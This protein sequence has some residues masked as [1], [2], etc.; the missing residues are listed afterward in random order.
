M[1]KTKIKHRW[2]FHFRRFE[3]DPPV[4]PPMTHPHHVVPH[5]V[6]RFNL[7]A[8]VLKSS[9]DREAVKGLSNRDVVDNDDSVDGHGVS[10]RETQSQ[11]RDITGDLGDINKSNKK[12]EMPGGGNENEKDREESVKENLD[13]IE[14]I[15]LF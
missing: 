4:P 7:K 3:F 9:R 6:P 8:D 13:E 12:K 10:I 2:I 1:D 14:V 15:E 5:H 11:N